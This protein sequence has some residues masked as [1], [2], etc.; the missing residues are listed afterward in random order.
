MK[1]EL[2]L[3]VLWEKARAEEEKTSQNVGNEE[4][5][6]VRADTT[7]DCPRGGKLQLIQSH[8]RDEVSVW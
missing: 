8:C 1:A 2:H 7:G 4:V 3:K 5:R 6:R